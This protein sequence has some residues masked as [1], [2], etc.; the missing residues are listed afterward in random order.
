[1]QAAANLGLIEGDTGMSS[2]AT[3][4]PAKSSTLLTIAQWAWPI[5][6]GLLGAGGAIAINTPA[7]PAKP[8]PTV[9]QQSPTP[10]ETTIIPPTKQVTPLPSQP[11]L[12][13]LQQD[14]TTI[15]GLINQPPKPVEVTPV[16]MPQVIAKPVPIVS[17]SA[18]AI[19]QGGKPIAGG[20]VDAGKL[21]TVAGNGVTSWENDQD[22]NTDADLEPTPTGFMAVIRKGSVLFIGVTANGIVKQRV[23]VAAPAVVTPQVNPVNP[24]PQPSPGPGPPPAPMPVSTAF[25]FGTAAGLLA[26]EATKA[27]V[28]PAFKAS[29]VVQGML[30]VGDWP[31]DFVAKVKA[32][33]PGIDATP[34]RDLTD[35]EV[36]A[37]RGVK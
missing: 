3:T 26:D 22:A 19:A 17:T 15:L 21:F 23:S 33:C 35:A 9:I 4:T 36:T 6:T 27:N 10:I 31:A 30:N 18:I 28:S 20:T 2:V 13:E 14:L 7:T 11:T 12:L 29:S 25:D 8:T 16:V 1:M 5:V 32:A 24:Q 34:A 37:I